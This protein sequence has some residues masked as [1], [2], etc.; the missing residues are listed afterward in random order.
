M[1]L[2]DTQTFL[3]TRHAFLPQAS[4]MSAESSGRNTDQSQHGLPDLGSALST[5]RNFAQDSA[6]EKIRKVSKGEDL[7]TLLEQTTQLSHT[8]SY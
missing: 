8:P 3:A 1:R 7:I 6:P 4:Q 5:L 2:G